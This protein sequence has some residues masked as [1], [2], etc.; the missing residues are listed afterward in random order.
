MP[1]QG[2]GK[3]MNMSCIDMTYL[4]FPINA[5]TDGTNGGVINF[6]AELALERVLT[7]YKSLGKPH[8]DARV[9]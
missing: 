2:L 4:N 1:R 8:G 9:G 7:E 6:A 3:L 5:T